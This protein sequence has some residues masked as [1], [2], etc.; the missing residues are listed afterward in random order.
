[1]SLEHTSCH[2]ALTLMFRIWKPVVESSNDS[3]FKETKLKVSHCSKQRQMASPI[4]DK[5]DF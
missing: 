4:Q 5:T 3:A 2:T 1:M